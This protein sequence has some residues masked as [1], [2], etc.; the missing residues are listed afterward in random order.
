MQLRGPTPLRTCEGPESSSR[1]LAAAGAWQ[2]WPPLPMHNHQKELQCY[3]FCKPTDI[4][5]K[6]V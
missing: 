1:G 3:L 5:V 6:L 2:Q 4:P